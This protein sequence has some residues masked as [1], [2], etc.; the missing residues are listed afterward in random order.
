M[1]AYLDV[2][3]D[4]KNIAWFYKQVDD[5]GFFYFLFDYLAYISVATGL[6]MLYLRYYESDRRENMVEIRVQLEN[7]RVQLREGL[8][9]EQVYRAESEAKIKALENKVKQIKERN[10]R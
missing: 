10:K 3:L 2:L 1:D 6:V 4:Q 5:K 9:R 7:S 8:S